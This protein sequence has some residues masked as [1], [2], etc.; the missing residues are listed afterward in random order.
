MIAV[1]HAALNMLGPCVARNETAALALILQATEY[2]RGAVPLLV[3]PMDKP[4]MVHTL[5]AWGARNVET[6]LFQVR[7]EFQPF[8]GVNLPSFL[9][10]TG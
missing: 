8:N 5:Y 2:Y 10:E 1:K 9:P 3:V 7:G 6:H 4:A